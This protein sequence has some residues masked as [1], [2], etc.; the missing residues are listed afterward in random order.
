MYT[1]KPIEKLRGLLP[2]FKWKTIETRSEKEN[3]SSQC[4][5][6]ITES[7]VLRSEAE[8]RIVKLSND[9]ANAW[10]QGD[11]VKADE[12]WKC[13][14]HERNEIKKLRSDLVISA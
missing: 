7:G 8:E 6:Q 3:M 13:I 12:I 1:E 2:G 11:L 4:N 10:K 5:S 9:L 14:K